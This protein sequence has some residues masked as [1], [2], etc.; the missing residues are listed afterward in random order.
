MKSK[1]A[2]ERWEGFGWK[3]GIIV[4]VKK[5]SP[6]ILPLCT[7]LWAMGYF[8]QN[9]TNCNLCIPF[10]IKVNNFAGALY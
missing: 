9:V 3:T 4:A 7:N 10:D 1:I 8:R 5:L 6:Y 2:T